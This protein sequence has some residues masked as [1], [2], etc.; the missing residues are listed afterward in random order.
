MARAKVIMCVGAA[1]LELWI[2]SCLTLLLAWVV[3]R[4]ACDACP[5]S[6]FVHVCDGVEDASH[7][8]LDDTTRPT[9]HHEPTATHRM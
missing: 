7:V 6:V 5:N 2:Y 1:L 8:K 4:N 9:T 3:R